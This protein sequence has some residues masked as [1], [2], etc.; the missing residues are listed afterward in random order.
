MTLPREA[1]VLVASEAD[2]ANDNR[3]LGLNEIA[4]SDDVA[5]G[6]YKVGDGFSRWSDLEYT[7]GGGGGASAVQSA[8]VEIPHADILT[9]PTSFVEILPAT[10][11][12]GYAAVPTEIFVPVAVNLYF[13]IQAGAYSN[14]AATCEFAIS[15]GSDGSLDWSPAVTHFN[16]GSPLE[17]A[18]LRLSQIPSLL[19]VVAGGPGSP[20]RND[21]FNGMLDNNLQDNAIILRCSNAASG[22]FTGGDSANTITAELLYTTKAF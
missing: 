8:I 9:L 2:W 3:V 19:F 11:I 13:D 4:M 1:K 21:G 15:F 6:R 10:E 12:Y 17:N 20:A 16:M 22:N 7:G 5:S 18:R 14:V